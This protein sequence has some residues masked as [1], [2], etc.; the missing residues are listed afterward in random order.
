MTLLDQFGRQIPVV[1][2]RR[3]L[4][5]CGQTLPADESETLTGLGGGAQD[6]DWKW[7][8][9]GQSFSQDVKCKEGQ[10]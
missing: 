1:R 3:Q 9:A 6:P 4:G 2:L 10:S 5:F 7:R 8:G